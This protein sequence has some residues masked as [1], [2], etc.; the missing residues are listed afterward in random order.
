MAGSQ[1]IV[2]QNGADSLF[3]SLQNM[4]AAQLAATVIVW[5][6]LFLACVA[7]L[8][9]LFIA[10]IRTTSESVEKLPVQLYR[11]KIAQ[12]L[13]FLPGLVLIGFIYFAN[14]IK[15]KGAESVLVDQILKFIGIL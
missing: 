15:L 14:G 12:A 5:V 8:T 6:V 9:G 11:T 3:S 2:Q 7:V 4:P 1:E 13:W 10:L